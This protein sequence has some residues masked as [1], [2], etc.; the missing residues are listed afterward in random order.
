[1]GTTGGP[2]LLLGNRVRHPRR[3]EWG[4]GEV[5]GVRGANADVFFVEAG[6][7]TISTRY[8]ALEVLDPKPVHALLDRLKP[9]GPYRSLGRSKEDFLRDYEGGFY[10]DRY[11]SKERSYKVDAGVLARR[12]LAREEMERAFLAGQPDDV[13]EWAMRVVN[14][15]NLIFPNEKMALRDGLKTARHREAFATAL[16]GLL[17]GSDVPASRF[18]RYAAVLGSLGAAKWTIATYFSFLMDPQR[19]MFVKPKR[20]QDAARMC[21]YDIDYTTD[22]EWSAYERMLGFSTY[23]KSDLD[24][25]ERDSLK[26]RDFIDVYSFIWLIA[27]YAPRSAGSKR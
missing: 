4:L 2:G 27:W 7:K 13:C 25:D 5:L 11:L 19:H 6:R 14:K 3:K 26:P 15:T 18:E 22:I 17:H 8:V 24:K 21:A 16:H 20:I 23:L 12:I 1:M 10:G 9:G